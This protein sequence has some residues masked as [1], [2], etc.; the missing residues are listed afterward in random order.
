MLFPSPE[1]FI[2]HV[3]DSRLHLPLC[4]KILCIHLIARPSPLRLLT[5][6]FSCLLLQSFLK[7]FSLQKWMLFIIGPPR[8]DG[9]IN[10]G[11]PFKGVRDIHALV[12]VYSPLDL[13]IVHLDFATC[14]PHH[15]SICLVFD[16]P[17][18][19]VC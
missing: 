16:F 17:I 9:H 4:C 19:V 2:I 7:E 15:Y 11:V 13:F 3:Y 12:E 14:E 8:F 6:I 5:S 1:S 10:L 18:Y